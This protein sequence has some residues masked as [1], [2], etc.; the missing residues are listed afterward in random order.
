MRVCSAAFGDPEVGELGGAGLLGDQQVARLHVAVDDARR[1]GRS[2]ARG[3]RRAAICDGV[4]RSRAASARAAGRRTDGPSTYSMTM[5]WRCARRVE[6][7]VEH[8]DDVRVLQAGGGERLAP[9]AGDE[10]LVVGQVL[11]EQLDR[12]RPL[13]NGVAWRGRPSTSRPRRAGGRSGSGPAISV[14]RA[15]PS[16]PRRRVAVAVLPASVPSGPSG[17]A[18]RRRRSSAASLGV[19]LLGHGLGVGRSRCR[20]SLGGLR[21][22][23]GRRSVVRRLRVARSH[24]ARRAELERGGR[25]SP[26]S[27]SRTS[28]IDVA[29]SAVERVVD[30]LE[31]RRCRCVDVAGADARRW[32]R[33]RLTESSCWSSG[34][35]SAG[36]RLALARPS[37]SRAATSAAAEQSEQRC[38]GAGSHC[39]L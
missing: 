32:R 26:R 34:A 33:D 4:R 19:G 36:S 23:R 2:R 3:R 6:A 21:R 1:G 31:L 22:R 14:R 38:R 30:R 35:E 37:R 16:S 24:C 8:L 9:E 5:K 12:H 28:R 15:H 25:R 27:A 18:R 10:R 13:E 11:G 7:G 20:R 29:G 39:P 17:V